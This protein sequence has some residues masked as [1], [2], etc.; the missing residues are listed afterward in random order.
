MNSTNAAGFWSYTHRDNQAENGRLLRLAQEVREEFALLTGNELEIFV[1]REGIEWGDEWRQ[2]IDDALQA[3]TFFIPIITP[4]YMQSKECR[5][6]LLL[7]SGKAASLGVNELFLPILY[8]PIRQLERPE[9][10]D[11]EIIS[12]IQRTQ[13]M[14]W[15][16][17]R[18]LD[19]NSST[20]RAEI[21]A[22]ATR[23]VDI[24]ERLQENPPPPPTSE[25]L[26]E[27][28][29]FQGEP[30]LVDVMADAE[31]AAEAWLKSMEDLVSLMSELRDMVV[32]MTE[33][34][35]ENDNAGKG[36]AG[37]LLL[38]REFAA[39]MDPIANRLM[40]ISTSYAEQ[41]V[42]IN[43][44]VL[45]AKRELK[46]GTRNTTPEERTAYIESMR[47]LA[48]NMEPVVGLLNGLIQVLDQSKGVSRDIARPIS[49]MTKALSYLQDSHELMRQWTMLPDGLPAIASAE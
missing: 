9:E 3:T 30:G 23:L 31:G 46:E 5:R 26:A 17:L 8:A 15:R 38:M 42:R 24:A 43:P 13:Y 35:K 21:N 19:E 16:K 37:R 25:E 29:F 44:A 33:K 27:E 6:E 7:F 20:Y 12:L 32:P 40:S 48:T 39:E 34:L 14:D 18:L 4:R 41:V 11:D 22:L 45:A 36:F 2:R 28:A 47:Q 10:N 1:D 49:K